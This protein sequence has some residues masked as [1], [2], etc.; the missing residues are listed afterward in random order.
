[1]KIVMQLCFGIA[2]S[3]CALAADL[4]AY[5]YKDAED[6]ANQYFPSGFTGDHGAIEMNARCDV[7]PKEGHTC[8]MFKYSAEPTE[9]LAWAGVFF[10]N[11]A[12]NWGTM[13]G[14]RDLSGAKKVIFWARGEKGGEMVQFMIG[15]LAS[16][17]FTDSDGAKG[18][19]IKLTPVWQQYEIDLV[20]LDLSSIIAG[21]AWIAKAEDN[22]KGAVF[23]LD[24]IQYV[25]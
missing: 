6:P 24:N 1:M 18:D 11:P 2:M 4:P 8:A 25:P 15:G 3:A 16:G 22:P 12:N 14:G 17:A 9:G 21:F 10:T 7:Q 20:G 19:T 13:E 23:Y 5:V